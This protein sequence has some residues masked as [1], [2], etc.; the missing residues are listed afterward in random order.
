MLHIEPYC[1]TDTLLRNTGLG[2]GADVVLGLL[3]AAGIKA[4][5]TICFD[6]LFASLDELSKIN[7][8]AI[9]TLR[10]DRLA[11]APLTTGKQFNKNDRG[12]HEKV[13]DGSNEIVQ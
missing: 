8:L 9:A 5:S 1:G 13:F 11:K 12:V 3:E 6:N 10:K 4:R 7:I 2:Q